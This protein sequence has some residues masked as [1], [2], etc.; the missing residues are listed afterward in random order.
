MFERALLAAV[1]VGL[2]TVQMAWADGVVTRA[3]GCGD[4]IFVNNAGSY[5]VLTTT[6]GEPPAD[7]ARLVGNVDRIGHTVLFEQETGRSISAIVEDRGLD[8]SEVT[9]RMTT[10]CRSLLASSFTSG[11][12]ERAIG[13]GNKFFVNTPQGYA[14]LERL[15]GG[16]INEGDD[17]QGDFNKAGRATIQNRQSGAMLTVFVDD[18]RLSASAATHVMQR[19]CHAK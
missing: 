12:V 4:K 17:V 3:K 19:K 7:G 5:S 9:Q 16:T 13:C 1:A 10:N 2:L 11:R 14:L 18:Y 6:G 15:A 8:K